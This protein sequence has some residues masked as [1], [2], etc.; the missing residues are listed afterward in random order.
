[1]SNAPFAWLWLQIDLRETSTGA[2]SLGQST[3]VFAGHWPKVQWP[4]ALALTLDPPPHSLII[5]NHRQSLAH[6]TFFTLAE[7]WRS[8]R[9]KKAS[10]ATWRMS[11][12][13]QHWRRISE[14][15]PFD[16]SNYAMFLRR[17]RAFRRL[18]PAHTGW[19][20]GEIC[21]RCAVTGWTSHLLS[22][23]AVDGM[24]IL[25][26][27]QRCR[28]HFSLAQPCPAQCAR[29]IVWYSHRRKMKGA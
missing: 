29:R 3:T 13:S 16:Q 11:A 4:V 23:Y 10:I 22:V 12:Q 21:R 26:R 14:N 9:R 24:I 28:T 17:M 1:M 6:I 15:T 20:A 19:L 8:T 2:A 27:N 7:R 18:H 25:V 5:L